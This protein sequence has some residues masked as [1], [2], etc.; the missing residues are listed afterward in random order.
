[1]H[2]T[3]AAECE[4]RHTAVVDAP[5]CR[6]RARRGRHGFAND[7]EDAISSLLQRHIELVRKYLNRRFRPGAVQWH[8]TAEKVAG[9]EDSK[10]DIGISDAGIGSASPVA[11]RSGI[12]SGAVGTNFEQTQ[13]INSGD[14]AATCPDLDHVDRR[15]RDR[16]AAAGLEAVT[17]VDLGVADDEW[18]AILNQTGFGGRTSH[19]E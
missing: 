11:G 16:H 3:G 1:M 9:I 13:I 6:M 2:R 14:R 10:Y 12:T 8:V 15:H 17:T 5:V 19:V 7:A 18:L 4:H